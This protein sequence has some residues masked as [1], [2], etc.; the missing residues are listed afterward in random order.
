MVVVVTVEELTGFG[1]TKS[2][3]YVILGPCWC[4]YM[5]RGAEQCTDMRVA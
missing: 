2:E 3:S 4:L 5:K 1:C